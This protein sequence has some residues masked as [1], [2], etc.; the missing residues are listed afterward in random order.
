VRRAG[1]WVLGAAL[2]AALVTGCSAEEAVPPPSPAPSA[3]APSPAVP[4]SSAPAPT[5]S[6]PA[7]AVPPRAS[8][9]CPEPVDTVLPTWAR[10]GFRPPTDPV[11]HLVGQQGAIVAVPFG[12]PLRDHQPRG[13]SN[14]IL[15]VA[16][17]GAGP[18]TIVAVERETG[19]RV[20]REL[21][22]GPGPSIVD[23]PRAGCWRFDLRWADQHDE[24]MVRYRAAGR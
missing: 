3:P 16:R 8:W 6:S 9:T 22:D 23:L 15:W 14:K 5:A 19:Q 11:L 24:L 4:S 10:G 21:P 17:S 1:T 13:R 12:W 18:L 2:A 7:T 20:T